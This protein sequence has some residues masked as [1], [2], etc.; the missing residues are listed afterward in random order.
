MA[1]GS[2]RAVFVTGAGAGIGAATARLLAADGYTVYA[3]VHHDTGTLD[4]LPDVRRVSIDVTDPNSVAD[5]AAQ[6]A[7]KQ[8]G[9]HA[10]V[11]NAG[12][13]VQGPLELTPPAE[14]E[15]QLAVNTLGPAYVTREFLP[16]LRAGRGRVV[17]ISAPTARIPFPFLAT[18]SASK[19]GLVALSDALRLELAPWHIQVTVVEPGGTDTKIFAKAAA[20]EQAALGAADPDR[21][22][23]YQAQLA[24][25]AAAQ[26]SQRLAAV[27][28]VARTIAAAVAARSPRRH[29]AAGREARLAGLLAA[30]PAGLRDRLVRQVLG[31]PGAAGKPAREAAGLA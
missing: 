28:P 2:G 18:L 13:I 1:S 20:G 8:A 10:V 24:A 6:V 27:E 12:I 9:L 29:Y 11:N 25:V 14:L 21:A 3:G 22:A 7:S 26:A 5:A 4:R 17:N 16:L 23:L 31:L 30:L 19:A 15:R